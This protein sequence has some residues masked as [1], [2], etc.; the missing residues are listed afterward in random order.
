MKKKLFS[1][2]MCILMVMCFMPTAAFAVEGG[3]E[4]DNSDASQQVA[5]NQLEKTADNV[6]NVT[7]ENVQYALDN[8][9]DGDTIKLG[10]GNYGTLYFRQSS[11]SQPYSSNAK[12]IDTVQVNGEK[13]TY[14]YHPGRT[15][16]SYM[17]TL[18]DITIEGS[19]E[20]NVDNIKFLDGSYKYAADSENSV[21]GNTIYTDQNTMTEHGTDT[22]WDNRLVSFFTI[23]NL[24]FK[25]IN[26]T[27]NSTVLEMKYYSVDKG[28][29]T[30]VYRYK[31]DGL[32][33]DGCTMTVANKATSDSE[34]HKMLLRIVVGNLTE[35]IY[36]NVSVKN[37]TI[38]AD[39][40][41][42]VD[43]VKNVTV[44]GNTFKNICWRDVLISQSSNGIVTGDVIISNNS[45]DGSKERFLR[46]GDASK[47]NLTVT[48]NTIKNCTEAS[49]IKINKMKS[50]NVDG[51]VYTAPDTSNV[52]L[53]G[54]GTDSQGKAFPLAIVLENADTTVN[55]A[56]SANSSMNTTY[57]ATVKGT[58]FA[59][60]TDDTDT[61]NIDLLAGALKFTGNGSYTVN[62]VTYTGNADAI[63]TVTYGE[64]GDSLAVTSGS[65]SVTLANG[66]SVKLTGNVGETSVTD[67]TFTATN[68]GASVT[69]A[70][71]G[72]VTSITAGNGY[73]TPVTS[74]GV[75]TYQ[76]TKYTR[77]SS[78]SSSS[79]TKTDNVTNTTE[80]T[81]TESGTTE[82]KAETK[83]TVSAETKTA[84]DGTK[85]TTATVDTTTAT[86]IVEKAVENKSEEVVV[87]AAATPV[88]ETAAGTT[89]EVA[90]PAET[91]SQ[92]A[93]KTTA[94]VTI[95]SEAAK[96]TLDQEAVAAV[97]ETAGEAG[98]VSL[99]VET[100]AQDENKVE[101]DLKIETSNGTVSDF[102]GGTVSVTVK[103]NS[104]LAAKPV[105]CV[106]IDDNGVY[107]KVA[108]QK[109]AD[110]TYTF[111]TGHFSTYA[112]LP[113]E[114]A[115]A[116]IAKQA[117]SAKD[118][119]KALSLKAS[120]TK[121]KKGN[122]KVTLKV[123]SDEI[124]DIEALGYTVKYKFYRSTKKASGYKAKFETAGKTYTNT[125]GK[126]GIRYYYK[127]R[128]MV[129]DSDGTL[130]AKSA[131]TQC[132]YATR[133]K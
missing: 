82:A 43:G 100:K 23:N 55:V 83:A 17:R 42:V 104:A 75:T 125:T 98:T 58:K 110:G 40:V 118:Y 45:S 88:A 115:D 54:N 105:M 18:K 130:I 70:T 61:K 101:V 20:A 76:V 91:V 80:T 33:L 4:G 32:H 129:Y 117:D 35:P 26:F 84:A 97:A 3:G 63:Y 92:I 14:T 79:T 128:V 65:V 77:S 99:V 74:D 113:E 7:P 89:T 5:S 126:K 15:D 31:I 9:T 47:M 62:D 6:W 16:V 81:K 10:D 131:L 21:S 56:S 37:C 30:W 114:E 72:D 52:T 103:L 57:T 106:Y 127:A 51:Y 60:A 13:V 22:D 50:T 71:S 39:R 96:V 78:S 49:L 12:G 8:A 24:T 11:K 122:I 107:H 102:K 69:V 123:G 85:T 64:A 41:M 121:T 109:N 68:S 2:I 1:I 48:N 67:A 95:E 19:E 44:T 119:V 120:S 116:V 34:N 133:I 108:G 28:L 29:D 46:I 27:G 86:K 93:E 94:A 53:I 36:Q 59:M 132:K 90:I 87:T 111:Q 38:D 66:K 124:K 112:I 25:N 73:L